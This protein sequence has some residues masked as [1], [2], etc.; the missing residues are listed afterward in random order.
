MRGRGIDLHVGAHAQ[1][2][3]RKNVSERQTCHDGARDAFRDLR[4]KAREE[5]RVVPA[6]ELAEEDA[7]DAVESSGIE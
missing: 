2:N 1:G 3:R 6:R 5:L 4:Q 7:G